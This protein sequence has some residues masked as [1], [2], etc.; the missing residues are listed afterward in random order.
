ML[1]A[2]LIIKKVKCVFFFFFLCSNFMHCTIPFSKIKK[3]LKIFS[4]HLGTSLHVQSSRVS[5]FQRWQTLNFE[6]SLFEFSNF[7]C[8]TVPSSSEIMIE[9]FSLHQLSYVLYWYWC[10]CGRCDWFMENFFKLTI[11]NEV[12][13]GME[14][15]L[16][17]SH[18][19]WFDIKPGTEMMAK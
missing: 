9:R 14:Y 19:N 3:K 13:T 7:G 8:S 6:F 17:V 16:D 18:L 15:D 2:L 10:G 11:N 4:M 1:I 5:D 12:G